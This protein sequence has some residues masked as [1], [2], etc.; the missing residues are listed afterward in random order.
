MNLHRSR[1]NTDADTE[2]VDRIHASIRLHVTLK[3]LASKYVT[4]WKEQRC[5]NTRAWEARCRKERHRCQVSEWA[6]G[7]D[8]IR[9]QRLS[10]GSRA[11][12]RQW[13]RNTAQT[14]SRL[15]PRGARTRCSISGKRDGCHQEVNSARQCPCLQV[16]VTHL[17]CHGHSGSIFPHTRRADQ[18]RIGPNRREAWEGR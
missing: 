11:E 14:N 2:A 6:A 4:Q 15:G 17:R 5:A 18:R 10:V 9:H 13:Q 8:S 12:P 7:R 16:L 1:L 3:T